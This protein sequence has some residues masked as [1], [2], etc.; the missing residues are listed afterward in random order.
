MFID[1]LVFQMSFPTLYLYG[2]HTESEIKCTVYSGGCFYQVK[3]NTEATDMLSHIPLH[4]SSTKRR[5]IHLEA[6]K[7]I[8]QD[9]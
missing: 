9:I 3:N 8:D 4:F 5:Y 2:Y 6:F 7:V 1:K